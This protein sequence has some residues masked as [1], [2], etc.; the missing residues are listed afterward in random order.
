MSLM[1]CQQNQSFYELS[2][3]HSFVINQINHENKNKIMGAAQKTFANLSVNNT[4]D[5][6]AVS[7][8]TVDAIFNY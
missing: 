2:D 6:A 3:Y 7:N 4:S 8:N 5:F 1:L